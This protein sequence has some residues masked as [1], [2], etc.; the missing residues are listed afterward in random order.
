[1]AAALVAL[2]GC[3]SSTTSSAPDPA[4]VVPAAAQVYADA[5]VRAQGSRATEA[6]AAGRKLTH[7]GQPFLGLVGALLTPGSAQLSY[8]RDVAPWLGRRAGL[9]LS[10]SAAANALLPVIE[11]GLLRTGVSAPPFA[12]G[13]LDGALVL[14][15]TDTGKAKAFLEHQAAAAGAHASSYR[16]VAYQVTSSGLAFGMVG[17]FAV[18]GSEAGLR[19]VVDTHRGASSLAH[20]PQYS[21]LVARAPSDAIAHIFSAPSSEGLRTGAPGLL[22]VLMGARLSYVS[23]VAHASEL[24]LFSDTQTGPAAE[25]AGASA[26]GLL[27]GAGEAATALSQLPGE[28]WLAVGL[29]NLATGFATD[30]GGL[31]ELAGLLGGGGE[32]SSAAASGLNIKGLIG[33]LLGP[34]ATL[35]GRTPQA[36]AQAALWM[37]SGGVFASGMGLLE[38]KAAV[39]IQS[40]QPALSRAAVGTLAAELRRAGD[41]TQTVSIPGTDAAIGVRVPGLPVMLDVANGTRSDGHAALVL[42]LGEAAVQQALHPSSTMA[43]SPTRA[44]AA[45][46]LGEGIPPNLVLQTPTLVGLLEGIGLGEEP[47]VGRALGYLRAVGPVYGG[48]HSLGGGAER[49]KLVISLQ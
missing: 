10:S 23:L 32:S 12:A 7:S 36:R 30:V 13:R 38:L 9:Y 26:P 3:G 21:G 43:S 15:T 46:A 42:G 49:F 25:G 40:R 11:A 28:S 29:G 27:S 39:I 31:R 14:D 2:A 45:A 19:G 37:G 20:S 44:T 17:S 48:G 24:T 16:G 8:T 5:E 33:G 47:S 22:G 41:A 34:L 1:M 18:I 35:A 4:T 6:L